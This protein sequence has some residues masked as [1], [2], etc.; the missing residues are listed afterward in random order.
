MDDRLAREPTRWSLLQLRL[1]IDIQILG[2][3]NKKKKKPP[4][5]FI[6]TGNLILKFIGNTQDVN[7]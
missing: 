5:L 2:G 1:E 7:S 4:C 3:L 6:E